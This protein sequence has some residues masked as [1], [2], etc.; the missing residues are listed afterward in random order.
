MID[1]NIDSLL[2]EL[3]DF[4]TELEQVTTVTLN[5]LAAEL[6]AQIISGLENAGKNL[7]RPNS[8]GLRGSIS[9]SVN[10]TQIDIGMNYYGYYQI[11]GVSGQ[12]I[13]LGVVSTAP[14][15]DNKGPDD[16]FKFSSAKQ[17][18]IAPSPQAANTILNLS[19]LISEIITEDI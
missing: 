14:A 18:S 17:G 6:P 12:A 13:Q 8:K 5:Q 11:F 9:A 10:G 2:A 7:N 4:T 3:D 1:S 16:I 15:F 19:D